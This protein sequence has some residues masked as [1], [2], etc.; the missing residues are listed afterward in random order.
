VEPAFARAIDYVVGEALADWTKSGGRAGLQL[1]KIGIAAA[2]EVMN[3][4]DALVEE[5]T[6]ISEAAKNL[7][8][9]TVKSLLGEPIRA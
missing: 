3:F 9:E 7:T 5:R 2:E 6:V 4:D 8:E 1:T